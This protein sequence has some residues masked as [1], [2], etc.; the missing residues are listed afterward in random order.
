MIANN[1]KAH[2]NTSFFI[3]LLS[4]KANEVVIFPKSK[5]TQG[6]YAPYINP[7]NIPITISNLLS[8]TNSNILLN[9]NL[10]LSSLSCSKSNFIVFPAKF[11][12]F[13][14]IF[15]IFFNFNF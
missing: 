3:S 13:K 7:P 11:V 2:F 12:N 1:T 9:S 15:L 5:L 4:F 6:I 8:L 10:V 14:V